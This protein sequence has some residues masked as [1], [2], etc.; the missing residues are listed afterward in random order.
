MAEYVNG[1]ALCAELKLYRVKYLA[2]LELGEDRPQISDTISHAIMQIAT[3]MANSWNFISYTYKDEM[4]SDA[5]L[6]CFQ[7]VHRFDPEISEN[8]FAFFSQVTWNAFLYRIKEE[9]H[10]C[11]VKA[12][13]VREKMSSEFVE[14]GVDSDADDGSNA[15]V[16]FLKENDSYVDY[17]EQRK[18]KDRDTNKATYTAHRNK[19]PYNKKEVVKVEE[20]ENFDLTEFEE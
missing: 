19:T 17:V 1:K 11:S 6:K 15:F 3:R 16:E 8:A 14:H 5:I 2:S 7:K 13:L 12:K 18:E 9:Q 4:I 10:Q 20:F